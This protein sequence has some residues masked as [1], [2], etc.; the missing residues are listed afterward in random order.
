M[1]N[2]KFL[3]IRNI[4]LLHVPKRLPNNLRFIEWSDYPSKS[5]PFFQLDELVQLR[6]QLSKIELLWEGM[7]VRALISI[8][9]QIYL[10]FIFHLKVIK[11]KTHG[12]SLF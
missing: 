11:K 7:K 12:S 1:P 8:L 5:L 9:I 2:L 6:L 10:F 4:N 3:R